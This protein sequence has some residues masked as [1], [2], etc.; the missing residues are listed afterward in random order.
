MVDTHFI[1]H[2]IFMLPLEMLWNIKWGITW[3]FSCHKGLLTIF[4]HSLDPTSKHMIMPNR[5]ITSLVI[6]KEERERERER[7]RNKNKNTW[8]QMNTTNMF[9]SVSHTNK[10]RWRSFTWAKTNEPNKMLFPSKFPLKEKHFNTYL[11]IF[12]KKITYKIIQKS[13]L[14]LMKWNQGHKMTIYIYNGPLPKSMN[15]STYKVYSPFGS[16]TLWVYSVH[17]TEYYK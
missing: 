10:Q 2:A 8:G 13:T 4:C 3:Q 11:N 15:L 14:Q 1:V 5:A 6:N 7:E 16:C 12:N 9:Q 17:Y